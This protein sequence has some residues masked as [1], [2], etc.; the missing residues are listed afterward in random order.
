MTLL[1]SA[2]DKLK[3]LLLSF[4]KVRSDGTAERKKTTILSVFTFKNTDGI[5]IKNHLFL[6]GQEEMGMLL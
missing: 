1:L 4:K 2:G 3:L 6:N 5:S